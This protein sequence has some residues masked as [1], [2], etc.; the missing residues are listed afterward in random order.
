MNNNKKKNDA[1]ADLININKFIAHR[2]EQAYSRA[3]TFDKGHVMN[4]FDLWVAA[5]AILL[6]TGKMS[7]AEMN[8]VTA[9]PSV[10]SSL[11]LLLSKVEELGHREF[12]KALK[13]IRPLNEY[14]AAH[15]K[16]WYIN[17]SKYAYRYKR[18]REY[19]HT[20]DRPPQ[21]GD[22]LWESI[23]AKYP[24]LKGIAIGEETKYPKLKRITI[25][26]SSPYIPSSTTT[27]KRCKCNNTKS[28]ITI[29]RPS[30]GFIYTDEE[31]WNIIKKYPKGSPERSE[32]IRL[33]IQEH[34]VKS[35]ATLYRHIKKSEDDERDKMTQQLMKPY[36]I[37]YN[38]LRLGLG[39]K[40][41]YIRP[42]IRGVVNWKGSIFLTVIPVSFAESEDMDSFKDSWNMSH[43]IYIDICKVIG[44]SDIVELCSPE[45]YDCIQGAQFYTAPYNS[46]FEQLC[47]EKELLPLQWIKSIQ[48]L[49]ERG[50]DLL[51]LGKVKLWQTKR[52]SQ[53]RIWAL[54]DGKR[55]RITKLYFPP[56]TFPPPASDNTTEHKVVL[57]HL[58]NYIKQ[59]AESGQ[60]PV[61]CYGGNAHQTRFRCKHWY[62]RGNQPESEKIVKWH[63][64][65][66]HSCTFT[67]VIRWDKY[68]YYIPLLEDP[69]HD[70]NF[71]CAWHCCEEH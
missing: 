59:S 65:N 61:V 16:N 33:M 22:E 67:F 64:Y 70:H 52:D 9:P 35:R 48:P 25:G 15:I 10:C 37:T 66:M 62:E 55:R 23:K 17:E 20:E 38:I 49:E 32:A 24:S 46:H 13:Y 44:N 53:G 29:P 40:G 3:S 30:K 39:Y 6:C 60:S 12:H 27:R 34:Y 5:R 21:D 28:T 7:E 36:R 63:P 68:G 41:D 57:G 58:R 31:Q 1:D 45:D 18:R 14:Q 56:S 26:E 69:D 50:E 51:R 42:S 19:Y 2:C 43:P 71:G 11:P 54:T 47:E 8:E 4:D